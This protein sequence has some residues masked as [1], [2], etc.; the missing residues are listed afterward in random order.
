MS[1][2]CELRFLLVFFGGDLRITKHDKCLASSVF[3]ALGSHYSTYRCR[4][5]NPPLEKI[6][7]EINDQ[8][9][10][11]VHQKTIALVMLLLEKIIKNNRTAHATLPHNP[12]SAKNKAK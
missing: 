11:K 5:F 8:G 7:R 4:N 1:K 12:E 9:N 6:G 3:F 2:L 10:D